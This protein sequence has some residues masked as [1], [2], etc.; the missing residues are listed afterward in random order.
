VGANWIQTLG[1]IQ[2]SNPSPSS[3]ESPANLRRLADE[4]LFEAAFLPR[5]TGLA[6]EVVVCGAEAN[7]SHH[8]PFRE[9]SDEA[10]LLLI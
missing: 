1:G 8:R 9:S 3:G 2:G 10:S 5:K 4:L 7:N 6:V